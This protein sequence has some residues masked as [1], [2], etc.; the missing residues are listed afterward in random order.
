MLQ[1]KG[2][3]AGLTAFETSKPQQTFPKAVVSSFSSYNPAGSRLQGHWPREQE[4]TEIMCQ[5][6][7]VI[8][9]TLPWQI[10]R[11]L[12][13]HYMV[14]KPSLATYSALT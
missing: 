13:P 11:V 7:K 5:L 8:I 10:Q 3:S 1:P 14:K 2:L 9:N 4:A 12:D 6:V